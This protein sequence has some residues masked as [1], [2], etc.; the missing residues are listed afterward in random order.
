MTD[1]KS[2]NWRLAARSALFLCLAGCATMGNDTGEPTQLLPL[3]DPPAQA[4][5]PDLFIA[6]PTSINFAEVRKS[7]V[8]ELRRN[9]NIHTFA[10]GPE[11]KATDLG[12]AIL[13]TKPVCVVLMN[14]ATINLY[15]QYQAANSKLPMPPAVLLMASFVEEAQGHIRRATGIAYEVPGVTAFVNL[16]SVINAPIYR[17]GVIYRPPFRRFVEVQ[18]ALAEKEHV[19][20]LAVSVPNDVTA[21]GLRD[22]IHALTND[23][24]TGGKVDAIWMLNDNGLVRDEEFVD[25]AWRAELSD[26]KLPLIVGVSNF[27][28]PSSP[29]GTLAVVPDHEALGLQAAN[30]IFDLSENDWRVENHPV[31]LPLSVKT[32]VDIKQV[33]ASFGL[34]ADA[35]KHIDRALE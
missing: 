6:M 11:T 17:V 23:V 32:V 35:L 16:R 8:S 14:N 25:D 29:F 24:T 28:D 26:A 10:V 27:V 12:A 22:A 4:G 21:P 9:F 30:L 5:A 2:M 3:I 13:A 7:L 34:R 31:E 19:D 15:R 33:R 18:K 1:G 20:L